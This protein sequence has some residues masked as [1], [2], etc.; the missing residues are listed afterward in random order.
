MT[1]LLK[2]ENGA[3]TLPPSTIGSFV[4]AWQTPMKILLEEQAEL[5]EEGWT[6]STTWMKRRQATID[7]AIKTTDIIFH[8][9][10]PVVIIAACSDWLTGNMDRLMVDM[11]DACDQSLRL[12]QI[13]R[14]SAMAFFSQKGDNHVSGGSA[15]ATAMKTEAFLNFQPQDIPFVL[16]GHHATSEHATI[17]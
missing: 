13:G 15:R 3:V 6:V 14:K 4:E 7:A 17:S 12:A 16:T 9:R 11:N 10:N 5:L 2:T 1:D 8:S